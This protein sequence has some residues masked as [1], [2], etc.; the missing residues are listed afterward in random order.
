M[1][2]QTYS[3]EISPDSTWELG[4]YIWPMRESRISS[5]PNYWVANE[6]SKAFY[7][8]RS[9]TP[10]MLNGLSTLKIE[11]DIILFLQIQRIKK[12]VKNTGKC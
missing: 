2:Q 6:K 1:C 10:R 9:R 8:P 12:S 11:K 3:R 5:C 7:G 4:R